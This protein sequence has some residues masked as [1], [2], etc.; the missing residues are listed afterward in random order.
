MAN[1]EDKYSFIDK[2]LH[3]LVF[4]TIKLQLSLAQNETVD[5]YEKL[6]QCNVEKPIFITSLP[7]SG[8]T[9]LLDV[10]TKTDCFCYNTYQDMPFVF[11]PLIWG[12]FGGLFAKDD[13]LIER[14]HKDGIKINQQ[15]AEAFEEMFFKAFWPDLYLSSSIPLWP[16]TSNQKFD[17]FF[18][19]HIKKLIL[20]N[21]QKGSVLKNRYV[22]KNNLNIIRLA[23]LKRL[24]P[25][26]VIL[27]PFRKPIQQAI[28]LYNQHRNFTALH[29]DNQFAKDYMAAIGHFD[30]GENLKPI[31]FN[32]WF[33]STV[34]QP[35]CLDFWLE[36]W[37]QTYQYLFDNESTR[38]LF[39]SFDLLC[40]EPESSF[41]VLAEK[42]H[43]E[44]Q[45]L[46]KSI[47]MIKVAKTRTVDLKILNAANV[48]KGAALYQI[49]S[50]I[51]VNKH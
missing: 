38:C 13:A 27:V 44:P 50:G 22:S 20:R 24:F 16:Q 9:I 31:N 49:L 29:K 21:Q 25:D 12:K 28:S 43:L 32:R 48:D 19:D 41:A 35:H 11:T 4:K 46:T 33:D 23:Y 37:I 47:S 15:S 14:A 18:V 34:Y 17:I 6:Q 10:L 5:Y 51:A 1:F 26:S 40:R 42:L 36:Y 30:F 39:V 45:F 7:R 2:A 3:Y 8:T